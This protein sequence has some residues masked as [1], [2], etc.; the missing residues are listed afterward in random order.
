MNWVQ[1]ITIIV[2]LGSL[3]FYLFRNQ[4]KRIEDLKSDLNKR[5][6]D[7]RSDVNKRMEELRAD[8]NARFAEQG[9]RIE[10]VEKILA[11]AVRID[12]KSID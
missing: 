2:S 3:F 7:L 12:L 9:K 6:E 8:M 5:I 1:T 11:K 4:E 10:L